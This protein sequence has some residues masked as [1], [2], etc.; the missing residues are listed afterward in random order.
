MADSASLQKSRGPSTEA[1]SAES[2]VRGESLSLSLLTLESSAIS[3]QVRNCI[4]LKWSTT[5]AERSEPGVSQSCVLG[6]AGLGAGLVRG[7]TSSG[8]SAELG[9]VDVLDG[10]PHAVAVVT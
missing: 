4:H 7:A 9:A 6:R 8:G 10:S 5:G 3:K 2:P 1:Q